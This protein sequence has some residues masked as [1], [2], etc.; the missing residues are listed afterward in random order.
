VQRI[1]ALINGT[2]APATTRSAP[3]MATR[4]AESDSEAKRLAESVKLLAADR[5]RLLAR[6]DAL[7]RNMEV[8]GSIAQDHSGAPPAAPPPMTALPPGWTM[9]PSTIPPAAG[10]GPQTLPAPG[11]SGAAV[12]VS[13][14][15]PSAAQPAER[16]PLYANDQAAESTVTRTEFGVDVGGNHT[17]DGL[18]GLWTLIRGNHGALLEGLRPLVA[19]R[20]GSKPGAVELR[21]LAGPLPNA[22]AAARLCASLSAAGVACQPT[23]FDGQRLALR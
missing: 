20:E 7:E 4:P 18:R 12:T 3:V 13:R 17:L 2:P 10:L 22:V 8:T 16:T 9:T 23:V 15:P 19:V 21:L 5:D 11:T 1:A 14:N 6:I